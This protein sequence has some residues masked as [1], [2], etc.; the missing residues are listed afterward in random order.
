MGST[1][2][3]TGIAAGNGRVAGNGS[4][5][6]TFVGVASDADIMVVAN[7]TGTNLGDS[8]ATLDA[9]RYLLNKAESLGRPIVI[10][11]SQGDNLGPHDGTSLLERGIDNLLGNP[12]QAMV[13]SAGNAGVD[14]IHVSGT[15]PANESRVIPFT[16]PPG[17]VSP[18]TIDTWYNGGDL[19]DVSIRVPDGQVSAV[20]SPDSSQTITLPN[21]NKAFI[22]SSTADP[23]NG[24]NR[25]YIQLLPAGEGDIQPGSWA[26]ILDG[27][28]VVDGRFDAWIERGDPIPSF[29]GS[30][31][32][33]DCT[34]TVPGTS[35]KIITVGAY[36]SQASSNGASLHDL[37]T[38]SSLGPT[39]NNSLKP[40]LAAPGELVTSA[41][42]GAIGTAQYRTLRG[43]SMAAP[44]VAGVI[45]L[46]LEKDPNLTQ[47]DI[48]N[49]LVATARADTLTSATPNNRWGAGKLDAETCFN[50][51]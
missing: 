10:N 44:H 39:R 42:A 15:V 49:R 13:K 31:L 26:I 21:G 36:V 41:R 20:I 2:R 5:A 40:D 32:N 24:D 46:L 47:D 17:D 25:I 11:L 51:V 38:F 9:V 4:P 19:F 45:A 30:L 50:A 37:C 3:V 8:A 6:F 35:A 14:D 27:T 28:K 18:D 12:G 22:E 16:V 29:T 33:R 34:I 1:T 48:K 7:T 23:F 43:T